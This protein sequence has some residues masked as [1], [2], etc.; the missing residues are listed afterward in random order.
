MGVLAPSVSMVLIAFR[1]FSP[2][3]SGANESGEAV[4]ATEVT[5]T[6]HTQAEKYKARGCVVGEWA[7]MMLEQQNLI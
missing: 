6:V 4:C 3:N 7:E 2:L 1:A 5:A